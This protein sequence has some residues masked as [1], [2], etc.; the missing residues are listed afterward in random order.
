MV[1]PQRFEEAE[2]RRVREL[3]EKFAKMDRELHSPGP[4]NQGGRNASSTK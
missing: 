2:R 1:E 3:E 4:N